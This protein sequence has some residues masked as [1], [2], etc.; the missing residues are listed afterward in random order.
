[1]ATPVQRATAILQACSD[2]TPDA[3]ILTKVGDAFGFTFRRGETLTNNQKALLLVA[4]VRRVIKQI[5][6]DA[7]RSQ[8]ADVAAAATDA[9]VEIGNDGP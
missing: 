5:T 4:E 9:D 3:A 2:G 6:A 7:I 1:M 8:A